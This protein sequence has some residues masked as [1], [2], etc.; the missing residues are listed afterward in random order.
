MGR[1]RVRLRSKQAIPVSPE[2]VRMLDGNV[3]AGYFY[4][5]LQF[6]ERHH[7]DTDGWITKDSTELENDTGLSRYQQ[8]RIR[9]ILE[10]KGIIETE[11][12][13]GGLRPA[14]RFRIVIDFAKL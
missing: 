9:E 4:A 7:A 12:I 8:R 5:Q 2:V 10:K 1:E 14:I 3:Q 11:P 6:Y 13:R